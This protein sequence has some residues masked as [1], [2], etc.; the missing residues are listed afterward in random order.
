[1][2]FNKKIS[3]NMKRKLIKLTNF[4]KEGENNYEEKNPK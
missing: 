3:E 4:H 1:M 2:L